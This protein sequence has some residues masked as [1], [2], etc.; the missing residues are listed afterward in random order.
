MISGVRYRVQQFLRAAK[1]AP[2]TTA[3][4]ERVRACLDE[5]AV[6][7]YQT[8]PPGDQRHALVIYDA[9]VAEGYRARPLLQ[10]ALLHDVAKRNINLAYRTGVVLLN[11]ISPNALARAARANPRDWR[12]PFYVSLHHPEMGAALAAQV[13]ITEPALTLMRAHQTAAPAFDDAQLQE[14]HRALKLLDDVN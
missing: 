13:G 5:R 14:W 1:A 6:A 2:L 11:K 12:Y 7:L 3:E 8:M 9:L 4:M 10:A